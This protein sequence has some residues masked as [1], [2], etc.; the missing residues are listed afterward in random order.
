PLLVGERPADL[1][2]EERGVFKKLFLVVVRCEGFALFNAEI[3]KH[4]E[5]EPITVFNRLTLDQL[6][7]RLP[8][9]EAAR[10]RLEV[11]LGRR[12]HPGRWRIITLA[13]GIELVEWG[14]FV[15]LAPVEDPV[16]YKREAG[17]HLHDVIA[18]GIVRRLLS[19]PND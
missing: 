14:E 17:R 1:L 13:I 7:D 18:R 16:A 12:A 4:G 6:V 3:P 10:R 2:A 8:I 11:I 9:G 19:P 5:E 15:F